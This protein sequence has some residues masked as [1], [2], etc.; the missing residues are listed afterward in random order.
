MDSLSIFRNRV[1]LLVS[2]RDAR[3]ADVALEGGADVIDV[4]EPSRGSLGAADTHVIASVLQEVAGRVPVSVAA[5]E[6]L[7]WPEIEL[8]EFCGATAGNVAFM[9]FGLAGC[10]AMVD[11]TERWLRAAESLPANT[12]PVAVAYAD[13][14]AARAPAPDQVLAHAQNIGCPALLVDTWDKS[15]GDLFEHWPAKSLREFGHRARNAGVH[16]A[17]AGSLRI[18]VLPRAIGCR[19]ALVAVR[20]AVCEGGR[21]GTV[22]M[23]RV[24]AVRG[25]LDEANLRSV[26]RGAAFA[27]SPQAR[28]A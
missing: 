11:W 24:Q 25:V 7:D 10:S 15:T 2:V 5:G 16:L 28:P 3:E 14:I 21:Q 27:A 6:L 18:A 4:K 22:S 23:G 1:G 13:W 12:Q 8:R 19:P 17:L 20:G 9:K 26:G